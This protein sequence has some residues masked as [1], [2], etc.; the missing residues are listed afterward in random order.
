MLKLFGLNKC[1]TCLKALK[2]L[3]RHGIAHAFVDYR[4][5]PVD[6]ATLK[7]WARS[8]GGWEALINRG[9]TTWRNLLPTRKT[10]HSDAEWLLLIREYP[11]LVRRPVAVCDDGS[12]HLGFTDKLYAKLF[13]P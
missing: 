8:V 5:E 3:E 13:A 4:D 1:S 2:W 11:A 6:A 10:P 9:G 7:H 12:V